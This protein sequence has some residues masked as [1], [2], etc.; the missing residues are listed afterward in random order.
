MRSRKPS[1]AVYRHPLLVEFFQTLPND[2]K[3]FK[4]ILDMEEVLMEH[5]Y[6]GDLV[7]K[8]LTPRHYVENYS[9][10]PKSPN[11]YVYDHPRHY[12]SCYTIARK[13]EG[14]CPIILDI[15]DHDEYNRKFGYR[16]K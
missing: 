7:S 14:V 1:P 13:E 16:K 6:S 2:D 5:M 10:N 4:M 9:L 8:K 15:M 11:L 12:R 3:L